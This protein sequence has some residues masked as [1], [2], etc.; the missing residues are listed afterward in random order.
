MRK[1]IYNLL[2]GYA[3][4]YSEAHVMKCETRVEIHNLVGSQVQS[5]SNGST[6]TLLPKKY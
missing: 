1:T 2:A 3:T 6:I 5:L 4:S